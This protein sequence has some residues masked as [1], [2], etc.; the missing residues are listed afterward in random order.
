MATERSTTDDRGD[1]GCANRCRRVR[2]PA[3]DR[4]DATI[5]LAATSRWQGS[6]AEARVVACRA[7]PSYAVGQVHPLGYR[8]M[9][10]MWPWQHPSRLPSQNSRSVVDFSERQQK[11]VVF[12]S[13]IMTLRCRTAIT[14]T[15]KDQSESDKTSTEQNKRTRFRNIH[16]AI[17]T[18]IGVA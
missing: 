12:L 4:D 9:G 2:R 7:C 14:A 5:G 17:Q 11:E 6:K 8:A 16:C 15:P 18:D 13:I 10:R 1:V 3:K